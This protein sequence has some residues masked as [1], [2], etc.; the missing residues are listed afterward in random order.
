MAKRGPFQVVVGC[1]VL[2]VALVVFA[3][4]V[5]ALVVS[6]RLACAVASL[7]Y[8]ILGGVSY[9][10]FDLGPFKVGGSVAVLLASVWLFNSELDLQLEQIEM[11]VRA[12]LI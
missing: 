2:G 8:G 1:L 10:G 11:G 7:L 3:K 6:V 5:P 9:A 12:G 4:A